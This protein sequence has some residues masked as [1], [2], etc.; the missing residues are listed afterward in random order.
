MLIREDYFRT[1][2][3]LLQKGLIG[4]EDFHHL[5]DNYI[6]LRTLEHRLQQMN[7]IQTHTVPA[8][9]RDIESLGKRMGFGNGSAFLEELGGKGARCN[10]Y[11][12]HCFLLET[13]PDHRISVS[14][15]VSSGIWI[16]LMSSFWRKSFQKNV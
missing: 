5:F 13:F 6:F 14:L 4:Y 3:S 9:E 11:T 12:I 15:A 7:D 2:H 16:C 8:G 1:L 10:Q